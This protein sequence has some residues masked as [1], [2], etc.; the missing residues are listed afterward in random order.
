MMSDD[1]K[2]LLKKLLQKKPENRFVSFEKIKQHPWFHLE[3]D[4][5]NYFDDLE[6]II[7]V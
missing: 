6:E 1:L 2:D 5:S 4:N 3:G 7:E